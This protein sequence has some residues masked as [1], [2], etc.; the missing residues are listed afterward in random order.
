MTANV[1]FMTRDAIPTHQEYAAV[2]S[3]RNI[4]APIP[5][6]K[7][8]P[9]LNFAIHNIHAVGLS[10]VLSSRA[11][12]NDKRVARMDERPSVKTKMTQ[13]MAKNV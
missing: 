2:T 8:I 13:E 12:Y 7:I 3:E 9:T 5:K 10:A 6:A 4:N 11:W 1:E